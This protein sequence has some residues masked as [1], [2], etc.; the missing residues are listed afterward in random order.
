MKK[1]LITLAAA[2][3]LAT[4]S[5][6][7]NDAVEVMTRFYQVAD[8]RPF[9]AQKLASFYA[10]SYIDH[11]SHSGKPASP[12]DAIT[13]FTIL[14]EG[15][16]DSRHDITFIKPVDDNKALVRWRYKGTHTGNLFGMP[17]SDN[18]FDIAGMEL[19]EVNDGKIIGLWHVEELMQLFEQIA[20]A[21]Q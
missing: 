14:A 7:A 16:P 15:A 5:A 13:T 11:D 20:P 6:A 4:G 12:Q 21:A 9:D 2:A 17:G 1:T 19:W 3:T 18:A 8:A 10:D